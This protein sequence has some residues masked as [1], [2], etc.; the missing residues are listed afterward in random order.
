MNE[1]NCF[2]AHLETVA[3]MKFPENLP[4]LQ[5]VASSNCEI[6]AAWEQLHK[7]V[8]TE[9]VYSK[10]IRMEGGHYLRFSSKH[11]L[12]EMVHHWITALPGRESG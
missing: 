6:M 10:V 3:E 2:D 11:E 12:A 1:Q 9:T 8:I 5:F 7:D 4:V